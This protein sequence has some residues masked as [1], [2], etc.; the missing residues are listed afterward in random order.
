MREGWTKDSI[1]TTDYRCKALFILFSK[2]FCEGIVFAPPAQPQLCGA[3]CFPLLTLWSRPGGLWLQPA[4][5]VGKRRRIGSDGKSSCISHPSSHI[6]HPSSHILHP[7][8]H[9]SH[10]AAPPAAKWCTNRRR[11]GR[12]APERPRNT[13]SRRA[14][15]QHALSPG[16]CPRLDFV[17]P[18]PH[19]PGVPV[20]GFGSHGAR[21]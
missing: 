6:P 13:S 14:G 5:G 16:F 1:F 3:L 2:R 18:Q 12:K 9:I 21:R 20:K 11:G 4:V 17:A 15:S 8:S 19:L 7:T 10:P